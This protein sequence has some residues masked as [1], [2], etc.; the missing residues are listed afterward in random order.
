M[1][2][3]TEPDRSDKSALDIKGDPEDDLED[4]LG[5]ERRSLSFFS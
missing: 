4:G 5:E 2:E 1:N 3:K